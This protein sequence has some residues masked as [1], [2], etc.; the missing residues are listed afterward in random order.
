MTFC[1]VRYKLAPRTEGLL[2]YFSPFLGGIL[3]V[4]D[5]DP[6]KLKTKLRLKCV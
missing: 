5:L 3:V 4:G 6:Y 2:V 1:H